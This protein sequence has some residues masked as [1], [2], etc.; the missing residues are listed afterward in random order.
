VRFEN[1]FVVDAPIDRVWGTL[2]DVEQVAPCVPGAEVLE[3][4]SDDAYKVRIKVKL[5]PVTMQ[6]QGQIEIVEKDET[7]HRARMRAQAKEARGQGTAN[8]EVEMTLSEETGRTRGTIVTDLQIR[9]RAASMGRWVMKD[10]SAKLVEAFAANLGQMLSG[11]GEV[12]AEAAAAPAEAAPAEP[13]ASAPAEPAA[14]APETA[15]TPPRAPAPAAELDAGSLARSIAAGRLRQ[16]GP[17][18]AIAAIVLLALWLARR[19]R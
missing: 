19:R 17:L 4:I 6:Y 5:G 9:G 8:A 1:S 11:E 10:V 15:P 3:R 7:A 13:S 14:P 16:H 2:L 18:L 12:A